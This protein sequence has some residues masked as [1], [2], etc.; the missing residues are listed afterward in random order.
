MPFRSRRV[1]LLALLLS[2]AACTP[3]GFDNCRSS[4]EAFQRCGYANDTQAANCRTDCDHNK[5]KTEDDD[6]NL[7]RNCKNAGEIRSLQADCFQNVA[8]NA[9][10]VSYTLALG[11]CVADAQINHCLKP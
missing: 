3:S 6:A 11:V 10:V 4:C 5:G 9:N 1:P 7:A 8:C 2:L